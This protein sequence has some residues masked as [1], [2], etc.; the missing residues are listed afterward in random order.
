MSAL[1]GGAELYARGLRFPRWGRSGSIQMTDGVLIGVAVVGAAQLVILIILLRRR[2]SASDV[3]VHLATFEKGIDRVDR[4]V[5]DEIARNRDELSAT[6]RQGRDEQNNALRSFGQQLA[7]HLSQL[8]AAQKAQLDTFSSQLSTLTQSN[9]TRLEH[10]R[11]TVEAKLAQLQ[12]DATK[13][14]ATAREEVGK[15]LDGFCTMLMGRMTETITLQKGQ[16]DTFSN[17]LT[18]LTQSNEQR[19]ESLRQTLE[20][21]TTQLQADANVN[22]TT[23]REMLT[24]HLDG[25]CNQLLARMTETVTFQKGQ[26]DT[27]ATGL[28]TLTES[29]ANNLLQLRDGVER[30][31]AAL[32]NDAG[33]QQAA[34]RDEGTRNF[35]A[36]GEALNGRLAEGAALQKE[37]L[38][39]F[40]AGIVTL[41][42]ATEQRLEKMRE[43]VEVRLTA[44]QT[45]N[46]AKLELMRQT[47][48][49]KLHATLEQRL[50][51]SFKIV[52]ERLEAVHQGLGEMQN[53]ASGVGDLKKVLT[54]IKTR[55]NWGEVQLGNLLEQ[56][57]T[58]DQYA[59]N[60]A[61]NPSS[62][63]RV[64]YAIKLPGRDGTGKPAWLPIDAKFP[65][66]DYE[67]LVDAAEK[68]D[69]DSVA[70]SAAA[71]EA[72]ICL[73]AKKIREKYICPPDTMD[74]AIMFLPTEGLYAEVLRRPG[75][76][77]GLLH[78]HRVHLAGPTTLAALLSSLQMGFRTLAIEKRSSE[79]W[80]VLG[81]VKSEFGKFGDVLE[82]VQKK[83][84]EASNT[85]DKAAVRTRA[86]ARKLK[87]VQELPE[88]QASRL[89]DGGVGLP[90]DIAT[91]LLA[92]DEAVGARE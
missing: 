42:A 73:E 59:A 60:V 41:S 37:Q 51:E 76:C 15:Y 43:T 69:V 79:V 31:L 87:A 88:Q 81:A 72:R 27:F 18:T 80:E 19:L 33:V 65:R 77:D 45:D 56:M 78:D 30:K 32:Q 9:E 83:L 68:G 38:E 66:E 57:F 14:A 58:P 13:N 67:R 92:V 47:V 62:Q 12:A 1:W 25:F 86:V 61:C 17:R 40:S 89:L 90:A 85:V 48:D 29:N 64:E 8:G 71:L 39:K 4:G 36:L 82:K 22:A 28:R 91:E 75:L 2:P 52:S 84:Q 21:K 16:F 26:F 10:L 63:D 20:A 5:R 54:N 6:T 46:A 44:M 35:K 50:G 49:E 11:Q 23:S 55:G 7:Q 34:S 53:L 3:G 70:A 24:K 74:F